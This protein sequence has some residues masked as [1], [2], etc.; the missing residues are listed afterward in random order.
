M[1]LGKLKLKVTDIQ[2]EAKG[3]LLLELRDENKQVLPPFTA[4]SHLEIYLA[5]GLTRHYSLLNS[6]AERDRYVVA[7]S[8]NPNS[9]GGSAFIH[10]KIKLGD[11]LS[12][13]T[14]RNHFELVDVAEYCFIA[15]GIGIT[16]ILS[17]IHWCIAH[18]KKWTL[19]YST[20]NRQ[21]AAFYESLNALHQAE[22]IHFHFN[23][24]QANLL[25]LE[26]IVQE[27]NPNTHIYCCGPNPLMLALKEV[28][29]AT[30]ERVHF[31]W[32]NAPQPIK[33]ETQSVEDISEFTV[34]LAKSGHEIIVKPE[35]SILDAI[36]SH[37]I[38]VPFSCRAGICG[39]CECT[40]LRGE[41]EHLD[42]VLS[43]SEKQANQR[44]LICVSRSRSPVLELD[45]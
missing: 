16:P 26:H 37:G 15:G 3:I 34:K 14:P 17:M 19:Y 39:A 2:C 33:S 12:I 4:G 23:D 10:Q 1:T 22:N 20:R 32:F 36:E 13:S 27:L 30:A 6:P 38:E 21:R 40:V 18:Q 41:P 11:V 45:L 8:L 25:D 35:Q 5:N 31:E 42:I 43:D 7:V 9:Q 28:S 24:E 44:M 29:V